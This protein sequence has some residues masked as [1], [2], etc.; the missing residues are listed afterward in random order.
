LQSAGALEALHLSLN[1]TRTLAA[2]S[3]SSG[4][5]TGEGDLIRALQGNVGFEFLLCGF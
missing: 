3:L 4:T 5:L 2:S 1:G